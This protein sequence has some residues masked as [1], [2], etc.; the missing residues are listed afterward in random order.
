MFFG[1]IFGFCMYLESVFFLVVM[2]FSEFLLWD[3]NPQLN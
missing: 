2:H 3:G 1:F